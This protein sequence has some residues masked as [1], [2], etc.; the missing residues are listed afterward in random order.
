M[1]ASTR[2]DLGAS[3]IASRC[4]R[5]FERFVE[6]ST[7]FTFDIGAVA[8]F[9]SLNIAIA[10]NGGLIDTA[11]VGIT[12]FIAAAVFGKPHAKLTR[13]EHKSIT[14]AF[15]IVIRG[16]CRIRAAFRC[17]TSQ[18]AV[19]AILFFPFAIDAFLSDCAVTLDGTGLAFHA[20][21][22]F[23]GTFAGIA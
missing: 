21:P 17:I 22:D 16:A 2:H 4:S 10:A 1:Y 14:I 13:A 15:A 8:G 5:P 11:L 12:L 7:G 20:I 3:A 23:I 19:C 6:I 18:Q 9:A